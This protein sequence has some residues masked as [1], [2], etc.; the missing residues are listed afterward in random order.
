MSSPPAPHPSTP[1]ISYSRQFR[2]CGKTD[3]AVCRQGGRGH[4]PYWYAYW[5]EDG[6]MRSRYLG[7][8]TPAE[9]GAGAAPVQ[10]GERSPESAAVGVGDK[11]GVAQALPE[12]AFGGADGVDIG[13]AP[14]GAATLSS[15]PAVVAHPQTLQVH[16][17]GRFA[18]SV[19]GVELSAAR[20]KRRNVAL[21]FKAL[22]G[23]QGHRMLREQLVDLLF[24]D[25]A[26]AAGAKALRSSLH[27]LRA[28]LDQVGAGSSYVQAEGNWLILAA[29]LQGAPP[30][31]WL[32]AEA[33]QRDARAALGTKDAD[34]CRRV[35]ALYAGDY[36][37]DDLYLD[38]VNMRREELRSLQTALLLHLASLSIT[39]RQ[40]EEAQRCL[41]TVLAA[42]PTHEDA[43]RTLMRVLAAEKRFGEALEV[44]RAL[45][46]AM[47][48]DLDLGPSPDTETLRAR[49]ARALPAPA[50]GEARR[51]NLPAPLSSF[52]GR[53]W[54]RA[55][56]RDALRITSNRLVTLVGSG[57]VGKTRMAL[58]VASSLR[59]E[60]PDGAWLVEYAAVPALAQQDGAVLAEA[61]A[62]VFGLRVEAARGALATIAGYLSG[63]RL[64]LILDN[65]E[66]HAAAAASLTIALL[67]AAPGLA[68]LA[69]SQMPLGVPG[70]LTW[71][72]P[73]LSLPAKSPTT[74][75]D[76][77]PFEAIQLFVERARAARPGF[78]LSAANAPGV[79]RICRQLDGIPLAIELAAARLAAMSLEALEARLADRFQLLAGSSPA[80]LPRQQTLRAALD[81][82]FAL[83][84]AREQLALCRLSVF[85]GG[86]TLDAAEAV[87]S[88]D[89]IQS[90]D[91]PQVL[92]SLTAKSLLQFDHQAAEPRYRLLQSV[93]LYA[94]EKRS[95][96]ADGE[97]PDDR[98]LRWYLD[99][100]E[101]EHR[102]LPDAGH[103]EASARFEQE[104][105]NLRAALETAQ[106][107]GDFTA[108]LRLALS[109]R[110][111]WEMSGRLA[112]GRRW[113]QTLL[114]LAEAATD[115]VLLARALNAAGLLAFGQGDFG[116]AGSLHGRA[117]RLQRQA[118]DLEGSAATLNNAGNVA[119]R[120]GDYPGASALYAQSLS[121]F[122]SLGE[123]GA[124]ATLLNNLGSVAADQG[125]TAQ[126]RA[127]YQQSLDLRE[128]LRDRWGIAESL[129]NLGTLALAAGDTASAQ[130][131]LVQSL[132]LREQLG[133]SG[134]AAEV[135]RSLAR[136]APTAD[137][138]ARALDLF[139]RSLTLSRRAGDLWG[140]AA[141]LQGMAEL[142]SSRGRHAQ[143]AVLSAVADALRETI[144]APLAP[145]ERATAGQ[146]VDQ[147]QTVLGE[148][149]FSAL[150]AR[151]RTMSIDEA[152]AN[153]LAG[154]TAQ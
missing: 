119:V 27:L 81:W 34:I 65:L 20:W 105:E 88:G 112:E 23:A 126:A 28:V 75:A 36:L 47:R 136:A 145:S 140:T 106:R 132:T 16:T 151:A 22:L 143:A 137:E 114:P 6:R 141:C 139:Q 93:L 50:L 113:L 127:L 30:D 10:A 69:T 85:A 49:I 123:Q 144:G 13:T 135:L 54:E 121:L 97:E 130:G 2:R 60:Y 150:R 41:R 15:H 125:D 146:V 55:E 24:P 82:S 43:A 26:P 90:R 63:R 133:D 122:Q 25:A 118:G 101:R 153:V 100:A 40:L 107:H 148:T 147:A 62:T 8:Q 35:L 96:I 128:R 94:R 104:M 48:S 79:V 111:F 59:E 58:E 92:Q 31:G 102:A 29:A 64:L 7:K 68:I 45:R 120:L 108:A 91:V 103:G 19:A 72:V 124:A 56:V 46:T 74:L 18:V 9:A 70:E 21:L 87:L 98:H 89:G 66:Q 57:G 76:L 44:Y 52:V 33:F 1:A 51:G 14:A 138:G 71:R 38:W 17:L 149:L 4:G 53:E 117:L 142:Y 99:L 5:W 110:R 116:A 134:G 11:D 129:T 131:V 12:A 67:R 3:C 95:T 32:D 61:L 83:L 84:N 37:P 154:T 80:A 77:A 152:L 42:E 109:L 115:P 78:T 86:C 73:S 39:A